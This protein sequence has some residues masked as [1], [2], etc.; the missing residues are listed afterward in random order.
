VVCQNF[1]ANGW[2]NTGREPIEIPATIWAASYAGQIGGKWQA[3]LPS[4][5]SA[6]CHADGMGGPAARTDR[7]MVLVA[8]G[9]PDGIIALS[10]RGVTAMNLDDDEKAALVELLVDTIERDRFPLSPRIRRLRGIFAKL[11]I[12]SAP[13]APYRG[14]S[15]GA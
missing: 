10:A 13:A 3:G 7:P 4:G 6:R 11:G 5:P 2:A 9:P 15:N 12:G 14:I 8:L 1:R